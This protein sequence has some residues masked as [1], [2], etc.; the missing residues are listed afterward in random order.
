MH[1]HTHTV[2]D[3]SRYTHRQMML[4]FPENRDIWFT[5]SFKND[6]RVL[7]HAVSTHDQLVKDML[8]QSP[9]GDFITQCMFQPLPTIFAKHGAERGGNV[10]GLD[11]I[12]EN[13]VLWLATLAVKG[14]DQEEFGRAKMIEWVKNVEDYAKSVGSDVEWKYLN[15]AHDTQDPLASYGAENVEL[16]R[17]AAAKYDP[18]GIFQSRV[19]GGFKISRPQ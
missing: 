5:L 19:P 12:T 11:R 3:L 1:A 18:E 17:A 16:I 10:L 14:A 15:Y 4:T 13:A 8:A 9:D 6:H 7:E 2:L